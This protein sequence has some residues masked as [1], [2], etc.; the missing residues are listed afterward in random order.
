MLCGVYIICQTALFPGCLWSTG[1]GME[2]V[3]T[4]PPTRGSGSGWVHWTQTWVSTR[5]KERGTWRHLYT[6]R[7]CLGHNHLKSHA[8]FHSA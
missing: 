4:C 8:R 2:R 1:A 5:W 3:S 6:K 7:F